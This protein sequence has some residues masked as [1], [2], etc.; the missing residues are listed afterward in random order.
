MDG[1]VLEGT[2]RVLS[3]PCEHLDVNLQLKLRSLGELSGLKTEIFE[4][5]VHEHCRERKW[6][7]D[8]APG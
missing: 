5:L 6:K 1:Q 7:G 8:G 4:L 2:P 3:W